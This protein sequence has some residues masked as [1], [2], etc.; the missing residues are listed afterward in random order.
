MLW[1]EDKKIES[2]AVGHVL[3]RLA[4]EGFTARV[5]FGHWAW[6]SDRASHVNVYKEPLFR[7]K[8]I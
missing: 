7:Q 8:K 2:D 1:R 3:Y 6:G 5:P 4:K